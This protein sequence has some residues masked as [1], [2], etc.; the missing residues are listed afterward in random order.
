MV[1]RLGQPP[2]LPTMSLCW[3]ILSAHNLCTHAILNNARHCYDNVGG[4]IIT[5][6]AGWIFNEPFDALKK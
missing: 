5:H 4:A 1:I 6:K 2:K 3:S